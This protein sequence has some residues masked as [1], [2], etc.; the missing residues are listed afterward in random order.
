MEK[1]KDE[2]VISHTKNIYQEN[3]DLKYYQQAFTQLNEQNFVMKEGTQELETNIIKNINDDF[4]TQEQVTA[5]ENCV[6][7]FTGRSSPDGQEINDE[8]FIDL[9]HENTHYWE[10][11]INILET[12]KSSLKT[13]R[14]DLLKNHK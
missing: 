11:K 1:S 5:N 7:S 13:D 4:F 8:D 14:N 2:K 12:E 6:I 9:K 3:E 10:E